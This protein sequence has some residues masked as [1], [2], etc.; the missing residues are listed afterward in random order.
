MVWAGD[1]GGST[2]LPRTEKAGFTTNGQGGACREPLGGLGAGFVFGVLAFVGHYY[3][4]GVAGGRVVGV[5][6]AA[7]HFAE[8]AGVLKVRGHQVEVAPVVGGPPD[9]DGLGGEHAVGEGDDEDAVVLEDAVDLPEGLH[10]A[11]EVLD[12]DGD[13]HGVE[14]IVVEGELDAAV[15]VVDDVGGEVWVVDH[16][17]GVKAEADHLG[18]GVAGGP[19]G[20]PTA[21]EVEDVG[22]GGDEVLEEAAH[23]GDGA[24]VDVDDEAGI[25]VEVAVVGIVFPLEILGR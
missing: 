14:G 16:F 4:E 25:G 6:Q 15:D 24:V 10:R 8:I 20:T 7:L 1:G 2:G 12:G 21:H 22:V 13:D 23:G 5:G 3:E 17:G 18:L 11:G 19:V 9:V